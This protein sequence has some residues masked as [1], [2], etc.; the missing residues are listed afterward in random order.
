MVNLFA[1]SPFSQCDDGFDGNDMARIKV[2]SD[3]K[4]VI[5]KLYEFIMQSTYIYGFGTAYRNIDIDMYIIIFFYVRFSRL[6]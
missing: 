5:M 4:P 2:K 3:M 1:S 6:N